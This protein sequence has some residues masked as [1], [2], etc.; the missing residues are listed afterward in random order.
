MNHTMVD[1]LNKT[2][3]NLLQIIHSLSFCKH[4]VLF[5]CCSQI[6]AITILL[7]D[8]VVIGSLEYVDETHNILA[9][10]FAHD[11]DLGN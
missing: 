5:E 3:A 1:K 8:V 11:F 2:S 4:F 6:T 10:K 7:S 9:I